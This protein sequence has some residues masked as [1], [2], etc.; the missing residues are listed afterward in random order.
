[1]TWLNCF[2]F[3]FGLLAAAIWLAASLVKVPRTVWL[4]SGVG[5]GRPSLELDAVLDKLRLQSR[6]NAAA[7]LST[8]LSVLLQV[9][10]EMIF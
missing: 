2:S 7:A 9:L 8:A 4:Q 6:L 10:P 5:G 3:G 1:M